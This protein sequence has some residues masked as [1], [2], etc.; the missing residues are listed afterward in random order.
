MIDETLTLEQ[1]FEG[2]ELFRGPVLAGSAAG[3][4]LGLL[5]VYIVLRRMVFLSAALSQ[6]AGLGVTLAYYAQLRWGVTGLLGSPT[7][8]AMGA[9]LL[10]AV[11]PALDRS[12]VGGRRDALLGVTFLVG[13]A[14]SLALGTRIVQE[15]HDIQTLLFGS[16]VVVLDDQLALVL[17]T[18]G[19]LGVLHLWWM[20]GFAEASFDPDGARVRGLPVTVLEVVL[21]ASM[22][23]AIS[24]C[25]RVLGALPVFAFSVLPALAAL[26]LSPNV[27]RA[28]LLAA[29]FGAAAGYGGYVLA[30]LWS[31]PVG[32]SQ[33]LVAVALVVA[34]AALR[35]PLRVLRARRARR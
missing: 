32:A 12:A 23:V 2:W 28:L 3:A 8:G 35:L 27:P 13:A 6:C 1:F 34:A 18:A 7:A 5:G 9:T 33:A 14:G 30:F 20:R 31:L 4:I 10:G 22:A 17:W 15:L 29:L 24:V 11:V 16:A 21:L 26:Q 19:G 25:T